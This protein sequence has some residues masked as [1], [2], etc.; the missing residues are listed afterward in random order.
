MGLKR[1]S[2][3]ISSMT[4]PMFAHMPRKPPKNPERMT[5]TA[6][7]RPG[8]SPSNARLS[9]SKSYASTNNGTS[10][11]V[12]STSATSSSASNRS[13]ERISSPP[14][15]RVHTSSTRRSATGPTGSAIARQTGL[16]RVL[17]TLPN[18]V[19]FTHKLSFALDSISL[20]FF[21]KHVL[22]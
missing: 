4:L 22:A 15:G 11:P 13:H 5:S 2:H 1:C 19:L 9:T 3:P 6:N 17:G 14:H 16:R 12:S 8:S 7:R 20:S 18:Y 10:G 21:C